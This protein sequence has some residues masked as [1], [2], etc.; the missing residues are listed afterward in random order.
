MA[1]DFA[2]SG[3]STVV[4]AGRQVSYSLADEAVVLELGAGV[5]YS[6]NP[7]AAR[8]WELVRTPVT[9]DEIQRTLLA[10]YEVDADRCRE[11]VERLLRD[12]AGQRLVTITP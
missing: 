8:I 3:D 6:L 12:F 7:V 2:L 4:A 1:T 10:E 5:Y 11:D 9:V